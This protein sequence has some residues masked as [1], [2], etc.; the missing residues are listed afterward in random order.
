LPK[1]KSV[2]GAIVSLVAGAFITLNALL[3][4]VGYVA[5]IIYGFFVGRHWIM[6]WFMPNALLF[7]ILGVACGIVVIVCGKRALSRSKREDA[8]MIIVFSVLS[9][10]A[11]GGFTIGAILGV[12]GGVLCLEGI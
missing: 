4:G 12:V 5:G 8:I 11:G 10:L 6:R 2:V 9:I 1:K 7:V 3:L